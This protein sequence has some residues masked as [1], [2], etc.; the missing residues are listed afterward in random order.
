MLNQVMLSPMR[1][2]WSVLAMAFVRWS[3]MGTWRHGQLGITRLVVG[4]KS[5]LLVVGK[6]MLGT[7]LTFPQ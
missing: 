2:T 4:I 3:T 6:I 1:S 7:L 5:F